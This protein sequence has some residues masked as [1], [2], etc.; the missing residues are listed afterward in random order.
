[1]KKKRKSN[2]SQT[3]NATRQPLLHQGQKVLPLLRHTAAL[4][5]PRARRRPTP[6]RQI[7]ALA[8]HTTSLLTRARTRAGARVA[9]GTR[10]QRWVIAI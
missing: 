2:C 10:H 3:Q 9:L 7:P 5:V 4:R 6:R 8:L 1:M